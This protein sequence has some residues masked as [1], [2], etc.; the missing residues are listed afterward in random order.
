M[1]SAPLAVLPEEPVPSEEHLTLSESDVV[2]LI[3][4]YLEVRKLTSAQLH[5]EKESGIINQN[6]SPDLTFL[7]SLI[8]DGRWDDVLEFLT[9]LE[10]AFRT[11][12]GRKVRAT[13][14]KHHFLDKLLSISSNPLLIMGDD[15]KRAHLVEPALKVGTKTKNKLNPISE[16]MFDL[17]RC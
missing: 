1:N 6:L 13:I 9:P 3:L 17:F 10:E 12:P 11:F 2:H 7:R 5:L 14:L 16:N 4:E 15:A 8:V